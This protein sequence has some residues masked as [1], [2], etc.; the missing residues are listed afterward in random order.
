VH[1]Y[2]RTSQVPLLACGAAT[3]RSSGRTAPW[4]SLAICRA[5]INLL[6][7]GHFPVGEP[8]GEVVALIGP[9]LEDHLGSG[10]RVRLGNL[11]HLGGSG[12]I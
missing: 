1:E 6:D 11:N 10:R 7:G 8:A 4:R 5:E 3:T 2:F 12:R 9:F